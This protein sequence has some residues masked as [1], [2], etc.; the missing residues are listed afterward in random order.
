MAT[1]PLG[2]QGTQAAVSSP[3]HQ[4]SFYSAKPVV[5]LADRDRDQIVETDV[6]HDLL[7]TGTRMKVSVPTAT[8]EEEGEESLLSSPAPSPAYSSDFEFSSISQPTFD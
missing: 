6:S 4:P 1:S 2:G 3:T 7:P 8:V 5:P